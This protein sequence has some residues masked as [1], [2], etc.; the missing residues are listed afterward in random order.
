[1]FIYCSH[2]KNKNISFS[3]QLYIGPWQKSFGHTLLCNTVIIWRDPPPI[4]DCVI[5]RPPLM[6]LG[7]VLVLTIVVVVL[8]MTTLVDIVGSGIEAWWRATA[9]RGS[10]WLVPKQSRPQPGWCSQPAGWEIPSG[11]LRNTNWTVEKYKL[12]SWE[13]QTAQLI[14]TNLIVEKY[15][16]KFEAL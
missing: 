9:P 13:M 6:M 2:L 4:G 11:Q 3:I 16:R 8:T 14:D 7:V 5:Y 15:R 10:R 1:M 12:D